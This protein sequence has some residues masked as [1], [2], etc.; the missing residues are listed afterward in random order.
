MKVKEISVSFKYVKNLGN[1]QSKSVE[2]GMVIENNEG[3]DAQKLYEVA[4]D[5]VKQEVKKQLEVFKQKEDK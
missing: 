5:T 2:A 4:F 3:E 1:Y